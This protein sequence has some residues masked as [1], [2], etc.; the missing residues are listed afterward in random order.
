MA[1]TTKTTTTTTG[2]VTAKDR[3]KLRAEQNRQH[4]AAGLDAR[5]EAAGKGGSRPKVQGIPREP[6]KAPFAKR[7][8]FI[9]A[10]NWTEAEK[11]APLT[12]REKHVFRRY[13]K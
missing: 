4:D 1:T 3:R 10:G 7:W 8:G 5:R 12:A 13:K 9:K 6:S 11:I 2:P